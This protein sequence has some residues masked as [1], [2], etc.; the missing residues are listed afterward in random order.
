MFKESGF[1]GFL[2]KPI[3]RHKLLAMLKRMIGE[4]G[5]SEE[6]KAKIRSSPSTSS[7]RKPSAPS[8]SC[9]PRTIR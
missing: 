6:L 7:Q 1:D 4:E 2:P 9:W 8:G 5:K 3:Q